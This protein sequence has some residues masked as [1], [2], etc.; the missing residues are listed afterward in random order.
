MKVRQLD[1]LNMTVKSLDETIE[2]YARIFGF[3]LVE[4]DVQDGVPWGV[5]RSQD[6]MLCIYEAP[7]REFLDG[8]GLRE[9]KIHGPSHFSFRIDDRPEWEAVIKREGLE[10]LYGGLIEWPHSLAWYVADPTGYEIE[11][12]L[13]NGDQVRFG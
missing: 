5:I 1:H 8:A 6:A 9:K 12:A 3:E 13:W 10:L 2:W 11:V 4:R 7:D